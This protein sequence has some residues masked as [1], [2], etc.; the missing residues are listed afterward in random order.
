MGMVSITAQLLIL[1][2]NIFLRPST[3]EARVHPS[4][5]RNHRLSHRVLGPCCLCPLA[6]QYA[7]D[8]MEAAIYVVSTGTLSGEY[9]ASCARSKCDYFGKPFELL[10]NEKQLLMSINKF[11]WSASTTKSVYL[12]DTIPVEVCRFSNW[13]VSC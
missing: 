6:D 11:S 13:S 10:V 7:P 4:E 5:L 12:L 1:I 8:F 2:N 9:V 3:K